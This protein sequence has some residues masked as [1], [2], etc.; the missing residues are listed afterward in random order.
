MNI[1]KII[2]V[3][4]V[5]MDISKQKKKNVYIVA[6]NNMVVQL[7]MNVDMNKMKQEKILIILYVK[8]AFPI[9]IIIV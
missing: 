4:H 6:Q 3:K 8:I 2:N 5:N 1:N 9:L 7:V